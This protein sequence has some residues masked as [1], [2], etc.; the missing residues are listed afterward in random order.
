MKHRS[1]CILMGSVPEAI[2]KS[3]ADPDWNHCRLTAGGEFGG[4]LADTFEERDQRC[5][6]EILPEKD[7][8]GFSVPGLA[9]HFHDI[10]F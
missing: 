4:F 10:L 6:D 9:F 7:F 8:T 2:G 5:G 1:P 3:I